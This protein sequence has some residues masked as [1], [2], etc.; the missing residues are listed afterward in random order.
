MRISDWS[1]DVCSSDLPLERASSVALAAHPRLGGGRC[2]F[3]AVLEAA[4]GFLPRTPDWVWTVRIY[5]R[6]GIGLPVRSA[7][8]RAAR[9]PCRL[10]RLLPGRNRK[11]LVLGKRVSPRVC[12]CGCCILQNKNCLLIRLIGLNL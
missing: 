7:R 2:G 12:L 10:K 5:C 1:S 3:W 4:D 6:N 9:T 11:R 8:H